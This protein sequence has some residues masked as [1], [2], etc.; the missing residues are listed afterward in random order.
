M[1]FFGIIVP[2]MVTR[3]NL[4]HNPSLEINTQDWTPGGAGTTIARSLDLARFGMACLFVN[5]PGSAINEGVAFPDGT[6]EMAVTPST[7]HTVYVWLQG[8]G[9]TLSPFISWYDSAG[10]FISNSAAIGTFTYTNTWQK[11]VGNAVTSPSTAAF[12]IIRLVTSTIQDISFFVDGLNMVAL[13]YALTHIDGDQPG[14]RWTGL[15]HASTS[16]LD[17]Q[18]RS[19]GRERDL[20]DD[21]GVGVLRQYPGVGMPPLTNN[22]QPLA[23]QPGA[24]FQS[25]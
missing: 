24:L 13:T 4:V 9:G 11:F 21:F 20:T 10:V 14:C 15:R 7:A 19:G 8:A 6:Q 1:S 3:T 5:T 23:L 25:S 17:A 16:T 22:V 18:E 2:E 12:A